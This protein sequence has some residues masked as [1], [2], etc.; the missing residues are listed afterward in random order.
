LDDKHHAFGIRPA[1]S[2]VS[3]ETR[4]GQLR[5]GLRSKRSSRRREPAQGVLAGTAKEVV[6]ATR[7]FIMPVSDDIGPPSID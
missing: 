4:V 2:T 7:L 3:R 5:R 6:P 1:C